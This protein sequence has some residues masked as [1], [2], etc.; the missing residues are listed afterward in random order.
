MLEQQAGKDKDKDLDEV[1]NEKEKPLD[2]VE[3]GLQQDKYR[4]FMDPLR[5]DQRI[6]NFRIEEGAN[7]V[8][9]VLRVGADPRK[10]YIDGR[11]EKILERIEKVG[12]HLRVYQDQRWEMLN[13]FT[14]DIFDAQEAELAKAHKAWIEAGNA[15]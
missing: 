3:D 6:W 12:T 7:K 8:E 10:S 14:W 1:A 5:S 15:N 13:K 11:I 4:T 2:P 9:H